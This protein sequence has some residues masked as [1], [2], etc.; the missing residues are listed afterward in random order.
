MAF[1]NNY[2]DALAA[3]RVDTEHRAARLATGDDTPIPELQALLDVT[4]EELRVAEEE[5]REEHDEMVAARARVEASR[6]HYADLFEYAPV[7]ALLT[8]VSGIIRQA[9]R[10]A[11]ELLERV[12]V[13]VVGKPLPVLVDTEGRRALRDVIRRASQGMDVRDAAVRL[14]LPNGAACDARL[15][16]ALLPDVPGREATLYCI[17]QSDGPDSFLGLL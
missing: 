9:N 12:P 10:A 14:L 1:T 5:L 15:S 4:M 13:H 8:D 3:H 16:I 6:Q 17:L 2:A 7:A 11:G